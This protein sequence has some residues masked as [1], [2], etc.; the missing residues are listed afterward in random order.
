MGIAVAIYTLSSSPRKGL[1]AFLTMTSFTGN[2]I[3]YTFDSERPKIM[4]LS[5][6]HSPT[7]RRMTPLTITA[8][9]SAMNINMTGF[10]ILWHAPILI[11]HMAFTAFSV[12]MLT[13]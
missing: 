4:V 3:V 5:D 1:F 12:L 10:A 9:I 7:I 6:V 8:F 11:L 2:L 13:F